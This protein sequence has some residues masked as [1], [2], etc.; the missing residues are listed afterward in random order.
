MRVNNWDTALANLLQQSKQRQFEWGKWDCCQFANA[1]IKCITGR[2][3]F[4]QIDA[5]YSTELGA[6]RLIKQIGGSDLLTAFTSLLG[7]KKPILMANRGDIAVV[8]HGGN[9]VAVL[10][11]NGYW[12]VTEC[13]L[14][15]IR[16]DDVLAVW[17]IE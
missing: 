3:Y 12:A 6:K 17:G 8:Q 10:I 9:Q 11:F 13:G 5:N 4:A 7:E 2:D 1:A 16:P 15:Q 14:I